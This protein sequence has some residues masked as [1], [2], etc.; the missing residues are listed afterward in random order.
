MTAPP[1]SLER[2]QE[3][4]DRI[5]ALDSHAHLLWSD[6]HPFE[7]G[8]D[9]APLAELT[10]ESPE[11]A[12][13]R[14]HIRHHPSYERAVRDLSRLLGTAPVEAAVSEARAAMG[15]AAYV[16][17]LLEGARLEEV[18]IDDGLRLP[19]LMTLDEQERLTGV[20][21]A[22]VARIEVAVQDAA[23][24]WPDFDALRQRFRD[25]LTGDGSRPLTALKTIAA[26]RCGLALPAP[27]EADAR[28]GYA[29]WQRSGTDRL[30][31]A[32]VIA[33]FLAEALEVTAGAVPLQVHTGLVGAG[34]DLA[35]AD[36]ALLRPWLDAR[37]PPSVP[38]VLLHCYPF[39]RQ[40]SWLG[41][42]YANVHLDLSM[43]VQWVAHRGA[44][45][46]LEALD[47]A[48]ASKLLF[49][50]DGFRVPELYYLGATWWRHALAGALA[51]LTDEGLV[52]VDTARRWAEMVL[53][54]NARRVYGRTA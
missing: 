26:F 46:V 51:R 22:R 32:R 39:V 24:G 37:I 1:T 49:A 20:P 31:E 29:D 15:H 50:T 34:A 33:F 19:D 41:G 25:E 35:S 7:L 13:A 42:L 14:R 48:P 4:L 3:E 2:W 18:L 30:T 36:P 8:D 43:A 44:D 17:R 40:A 45:L 11:P 54:D 9:A 47:V 12:E 27:S 16:R 21:V 5:P 38:V 6:A 52:G 28:A 23:A 53:R 10:L